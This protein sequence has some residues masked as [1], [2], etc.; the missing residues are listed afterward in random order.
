MKLTNS[1]SKRKLEEEIK[2]ILTKMSETDPETKEYTAMAANLETLIQAQNVK[3][4]KGIGMDTV[5]IIA[6]NLLGILLILGYE[7]ASIIT[8]KALSFVIRGRV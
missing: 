2:S 1:N 5:A 8:T 4:A 6:G 7:K 3:K